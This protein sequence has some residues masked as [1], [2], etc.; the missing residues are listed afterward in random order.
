MRHYAEEDHGTAKPWE[1]NPSAEEPYYQV[2][3][4]PLDI[5]LRIGKLLYKNHWRWQRRLHPEHVQFI[6]NDGNNFGLSKGGSNILVEE[7]SALGHYFVEPV[8]LRKEYIDRARDELERRWQASVAAARR[9]TPSRKM[10]RYDVDD[11]NCQHYFA[12]VLRLAASYET[13]ELP[14]VLSH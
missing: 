14:L 6:G 9:S 7:K 12:E 8:K 2:A 3:V 4:R 13:P 5:P 11:Y 10:T 1:P